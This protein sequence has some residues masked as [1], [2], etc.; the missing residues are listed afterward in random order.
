M[1]IVTASMIIA[2]E[3]IVVMSAYIYHVIPLKNYSRNI[4]RVQIIL[5]SCS[6][7]LGGVAFF[8]VKNNY[9]SGIFYG[10]KWD[11]AL[12]AIMLLLIFLCFLMSILRFFFNRNASQN[13][14][15]TFLLKAGEYRIV[16]D[17]DLMMGDYFY[18]P[19][20]KSYCEFDGGKIFFAGS[21]PE[22]DV[23]CSFTCRMVKDGIYECLS[24]EILNK[25]I[26]VRLAQIIQIVF[27]ILIAVDFALAMI[28]LSQAPELNIDL[29]GRLT[30]FLS[31]SLF[32]IGGLK[33]FKGAKGIGAI[34]M[35]ITGYLII[36]AGIFS[37]I[38]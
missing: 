36:L 1:F 30:S 15:E 7:I 20:V 19:N 11:E 37:F 23:D 4:T 34:L 3:L 9:N 2:W 13:S 26:K 35:K 8:Y 16:K 10:S 5:S 32:G 28:W 33:L 22:K 17:L 25:D 21:V 31:L 24:Y 18:M 38:K 12:V 14:E 6:V 29:I 27:F